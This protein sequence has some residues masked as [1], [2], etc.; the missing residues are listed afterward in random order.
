MKKKILV[1]ISVIA[2]MFLFAIG[3][4]AYD[5]GDVDGNSKITAADARIALRAAAKITEL[6]DEQFAAADVDANGR[7]TA[8][9]AR[10]I[11]RVAAQ[12]DHFSSDGNGKKMEIHASFS[13]ICLKRGGTATIGFELNGSYDTSLSVSYDTSCFKTEWSDWYIDPQGNDIIFLFVSAVTNDAAPSDI[14]VYA[15][16][17]PSVKATVKASVSQANGWDDYGGDAGIPDFGAFTGVE[18]DFYYLSDDATGTSFFYSY[19]EVWQNCDDVSQVMT[20]YIYCLYDFDFVFVQDGYDEDGYYS[21]Y[22]Y[23]EE[24]NIYL[25][26]TSIDEDGV[27]MSIQITFLYAE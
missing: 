10:T 27:T 1:F 24:Y 6:T 18:P 26:I 4:S 15:D 12:I 11:L 2:C 25:S 23:N 13:E 14:I 17:D 22:F 16:T 3:A 21:A 19:Y 8:S 9:D 20:D 5:I 7:I